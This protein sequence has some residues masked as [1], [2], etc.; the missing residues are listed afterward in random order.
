M[1][2]TIEAG[3]IAKQVIRHEFD[4]NKK[5]M[6]SESPSEMTGFLG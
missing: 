5:R 4:L 1:A 6:N 3:Q 2:R